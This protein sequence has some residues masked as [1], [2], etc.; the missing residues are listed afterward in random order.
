MLPEP[1]NPTVYQPVP[2]PTRPAAGPL[3]PVPGR[4]IVG[5]QR[6]AD[7]LMIPVYE[8]AVAV[9]RTE[10][11]D[12][13]PQ[14]LFDPVAQR[15]VGGGVFAAGIGLGGWLLFSALAGATTALALLVGVLLLAKLPAAGSRGGNTIHVHQR[16]GIFGRNH[17]TNR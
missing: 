6:Y 12:L 1:R 11:R 8:T 14:P 4:R 3:A 5:Y 7:D 13:T 2:L 16:A 9:V 15:L 17:N 10:P